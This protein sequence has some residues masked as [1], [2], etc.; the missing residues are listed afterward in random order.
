[1]QYCRKIPGFHKMTW[2]HYH[3]NANPAWQLAIY[4]MRSVHKQ[5]ESMHWILFELVLTIMCAAFMASG[6]VRQQTIGVL[7]AVYATINPKP[8]VIVIPMVSM[9][10]CIAMAAVVPS[11]AVRTFGNER[12]QFWREASTARMWHGSYFLGTLTAQFYRYVL[13]SLHFTVIAYFMWNPLSGFWPLYLVLLLTYACFDAQSIILGALIDPRNAPVM[14]TVLSVGIALFNGYPGV[15]YV[16]YGSFTW[17]AT[18]AI[19]TINMDP[20]N[21]VW[22]VKIVNYIE[23]RLGRYRIDIAILIAILIFYS[24]GGGLILWLMYRDKQK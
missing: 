7:P 2:F 23:Y 3:G 10:Y 1:M 20:M 12:Q 15:P 18:E 4:H 17:Y 16:G 22:D 13:A 19:Y 24:F 21:A 9:F 14:A 11:I 6:A 8:L 5:L